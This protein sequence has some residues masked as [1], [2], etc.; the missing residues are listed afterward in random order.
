MT[1][2][3]TLGRDPDRLHGLDDVPTVVD[4][5]DEL[6]L[7]Q[8]LTVSGHPVRQATLHVVTP[9]VDGRGV[10]VHPGIGTPGVV[11]GGRLGGRVVPRPGPDVTRTTVRA[12]GGSPSGGL[13]DVVPWG[14]L[15]PCGDLIHVTGGRGLGGPLGALGPPLA[16]SLGVTEDVGQEPV[17]DG[18]IGP[19][20]P[21]GPLLALARR[22][23]DIGVLDPGHPLRSGLPVGEGGRGLRRELQALGEPE[24]EVATTAVD[25]LPGVG[26]LDAGGG[27]GGSHPRQGRISRPLGPGLAE[28]VQLGH[29]VHVDD[30]QPGPAD[31]QGHVDRRVR[32]AVLAV[33]VDPP[34][35]VGGVVGGHV[36][37]GGL[38]LPGLGGLLDRLV[39]GLGGPAIGGLL[40]TGDHQEQ[41]QS[42][43][44]LEGLGVGL[45]GGV[46]GV[47]PWGRSE[48]RGEFR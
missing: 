42:G 43:V 1:G 34:A 38:G 16:P 21:V 14:G 19:A 9:D 15:G 2:V 41:R 18:V 26:V 44:G 10:G 48:E 4:R 32:V 31:L 35:E 40:A 29:G 22:D 20:H 45:E 6:E 47:G 24:V 3:L 12:S 23:E 37:A 27:H 46:V 17:R 7:A 39:A 25:P 36:E 30:H 28:R 11:S 5:G 33:L 8:G 13:Q